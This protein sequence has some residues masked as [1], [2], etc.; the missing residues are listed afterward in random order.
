MPDKNEQKVDAIQAF[1][2]QKFP[3]ILNPI[4]ASLYSSDLLFW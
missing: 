4:V 2:R 3:P 1:E